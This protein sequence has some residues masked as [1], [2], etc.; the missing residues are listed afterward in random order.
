MDLCYN[1]AEV[2]KMFNRVDNTYNDLREN[3]LNQW[4]DEMQQ[5]ED[6]AVRGGVKLCREYIEH[7]KAENKLLEDKDKL[8][9]EY[10]RKLKQEK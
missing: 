1:I 10:L 8:K 2:N 9:S 3:S 5:H 6:I 4:L 7:L